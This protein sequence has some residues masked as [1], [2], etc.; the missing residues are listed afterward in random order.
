DRA[1]ADVHILGTSQSTGGGGREYTLAFIGLR[2]F[3]GLTDTLR[4]VG[5]STETDDERRKGLAKV[6]K[7]GLVRF[8]ARTTIADRLQIS[9]SGGG[10]A[11]PAQTQRDPWNFWVFRVS[12]FANANGD[13][14]GKFMY[15]NG[16]FDARRLTERWKL[17][18][19]AS[20]NYN[21]SDFTI[22]GE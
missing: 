3:N 19:N 16:N 4:Y 2:D 14:N 7:T 21:Q 13:A 8:L 15:I 6:V 22:E 17:M 11:A 10:A 20:E 5:G 12:T 9:V 1:V 18:F